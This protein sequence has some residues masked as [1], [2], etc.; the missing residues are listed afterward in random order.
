MLQIQDILQFALVPTILSSIS[1]VAF[2]E[3]FKNDQPQVT[4]NVMK[5][6]KVVKLILIKNL[7]GF[8]A[9]YIC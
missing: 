4:P 5:Y 3:V 2:E 6:L 1:V 8:D 7:A 9:Y